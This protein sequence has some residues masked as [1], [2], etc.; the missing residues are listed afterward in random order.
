MLVAYNLANFLRQLVLPK[1][2]L[3]WTLTTLR[4]KLVKF[5]GRARGKRLVRW[6]EAATE[7]V[8]AARFGGKIL[9]IAPLGIRLTCWPS[10]PRRGTGPSRKDRL[11]GLAAR[12]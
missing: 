10:Y 8:A 5:G 11:D 12:E 2:I 1:P 7:R 6:V 3:G 4:E 9:A